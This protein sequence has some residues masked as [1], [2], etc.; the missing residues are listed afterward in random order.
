MIKIKEKRSGKQSIL[1][2]VNAE[3]FKKRL[4]RYVVPISSQTEFESQKLWAKVSDAIKAGDQKVATIEK[5]KLEDQQRRETKFR[6]ENNIKHEPRL[7]EFD[8]LT[9]DWH[10]KY[11]DMRPWDNRTDIVQFEKSFVIQTLTK[12]R[13]MSKTSLINPVESSPVLDFNKVT[14]SNLTP[15]QKAVVRRRSPKLKSKPKSSNQIDSKKLNDGLPIDQTIKKS[16]TNDGS[17]NKFDSIASDENLDDTDY[18]STFKNSST[19]ANQLIKRI[20]HN[21]SEFK[22]SLN[23]LKDRQQKLEKIILEERKKSSTKKSSFVR[24][25]MNTQFLSYS[26]ILTLFVL[27]VL[28]QLIIYKFNNN[29][30]YLRK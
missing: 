18:S 27:T 17:I 20:E 14:Y 2:E 30:N 11:E 9:N 28:I 15:Q 12:H 6:L 1:W 10:Y 16:D 26:N 21:E 19:L 5:T 24:S 25:L 8:E 3:T 22:E 23:K 4:K 13:T 7:F 29:S